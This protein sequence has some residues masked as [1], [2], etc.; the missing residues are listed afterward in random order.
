MS[1]YLFKSN[2]KEE[3][4]VLKSINPNLFSSWMELH[5]TV[6]ADGALSRKEKELISVAGAHI[7]RCPYCIK[8]RVKSA[9]RAGAT[10][11]E[12]VEAIYVAMRF[13]MGAP[14]AYSSISFETYNALQNDESITEGNL[15]SKN[16]SKE[17][18]EFREAS[19]GISKP[20]MAF[21]QNV[22]ADGALSKKL[23]RGIIGL[24]VAHMTKCPWCIRG[25]T[26]DALD[27][28][29]TKEQIAEAI[30]VAMIMSAGACFAHTGLAMETLQEI[31]ERKSK[32]S[33]AAAGGAGSAGKAESAAVAQS[34]LKDSPGDIDCGC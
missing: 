31:K 26:K 19:G 4:G 24:A 20:F 33:P 17:I 30:N 13:A 10:D 23:K 29:F 14:F 12:I 18:G 15:F 5:D 8:A 7:T 25:C 22:F 34:N 2:I 28:G 6:F 16:I 27:F 11:E 21:H 9:N 32:G 3:I 1:E